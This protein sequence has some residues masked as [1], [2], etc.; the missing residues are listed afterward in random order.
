[1][2]GGGSELEG[3]LAPALDATE[4]SSVRAVLV[5]GVE[6]LQL[7]STLTVDAS[8]QAA[9]LSRSVGEE[10]S[11][12]IATQ[13]ALEQRFEQ[14]IAARSV[15]RTMP[16]KKKFEENQ[17]QLHEVANQLRQTTAQLC[18]NLKENPNLTE[19]LLKIQL[20]RSSFQTLLSQ[21]IAE[22]EDR[23]E[24]AT[25]TSLVSDEAEHER[26]V[27]ETLA[28][29][30]AASA[31]VKE[32]KQLLKDEKS[33]HD[34]TTSSKKELLSARK[35]EL[36]ELKSSTG[37]VNRYKDKEY[38]AG[39]RCTSRVY[40]QQVDSLE[41]EVAALQAQIAMEKRAHQS[42]AE[43][44][45]RKASELQDQVL[46]WMQKHENDT[47]AKDRALAT[48]KNVHERDRVYLKELEQNYQTE[49]AERAVRLPEEKRQK[50]L[51]NTAAA[52]D[53]IRARAAAKIQALYR[54]W[55]ARGGDAAGGKK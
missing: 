48:L 11:Q 21:C 13:N 36:K 29:E 30:K 49:L 1:M 2:R 44:L 52:H 9:E 19:N 4:A 27:R 34:S 37:I 42:T 26:T 25:L 40:N 28:S 14:L 55:N 50:E 16:N 51:M 23:A 15:L 43:F 20:E 31:A 54:G 53:E 39:N 3:A 22:I 12:V 47:Q 33:D 38:N 35:E 17:D 8:V 41:G 5:A 46:H 18:R 6:K 10:I 24:Y 32:L 7:L 45:K